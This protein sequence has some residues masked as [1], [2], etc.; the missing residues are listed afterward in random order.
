MFNDL[1]T[2][3]LM[4]FSIFIIIYIYIYTQKKTLS[5]LELQH[6]P[7]L[8]RKEKEGRS[9]FSFPTAVDHNSVGKGAGGAHMRP[10][11]TGK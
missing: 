6:P 1:F 4:C 11:P 2:H 5:S 7:P 9:F 8:P 10:R 3:F